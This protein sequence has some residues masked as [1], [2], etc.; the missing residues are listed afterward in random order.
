MSGIRIEHHPDQGR[1]D[2]LGVFAWPVWTKEIS[3]FPWHY[4]SAETCYVVGGEVVVTPE[5]GAPA[6]IGVG[7]LA[8]FPA[9][10]SCTWE[11]RA[12][13]RKHYRFD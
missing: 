10:M 5:H 2:A 7:D 6:P 11:V 9:G 12:P 3:S 8:I 4:D 1:L 13:V